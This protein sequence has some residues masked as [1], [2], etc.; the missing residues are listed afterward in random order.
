MGISPPL[1]YSTT[2]FSVVEL[3]RTMTSL[4]AKKKKDKAR[5]MNIAKTRKAALAALDNHAH[6][7]KVVVP[8]RLRAFYAGDFDRHHLTYATGKVLSWGNGTFQLALT[9]PTWLDKGDDAVNGPGGD[10][11]DAKHHVPIFV[12]SDGLY[13]VVDIRNPECPTA[14]Y[15]EEECICSGPAKAASSL[16]AFLATLS[17]EGAGDDITTPADPD[18]RDHWAQDFSDDSPRVFDAVRDDD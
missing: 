6:R 16:D 1:A 4:A 7:Y 13:V 11:K 3:D 9:P 5:S 2:T 15:H 18:Q 14:W 10:W 17:R 12:T 8:D